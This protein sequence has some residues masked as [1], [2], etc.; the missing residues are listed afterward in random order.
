VAEVMRTRVGELV[1]LPAPDTREAEGT[2]R[3]VLRGAHEEFAVQEAPWP[4]DEHE[5]AQHQALQRPLGLEGAPGTTERRVAVGA[6]F[7]PFGY[8][9]ALQ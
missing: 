5:A 1:E 4:E 8:R 3:R 7:S 2:L 6:G 9:R